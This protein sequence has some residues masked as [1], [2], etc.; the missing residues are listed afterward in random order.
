MK[1][2]P[3]QVIKTYSISLSEKEIKEIFQCLNYCSHRL[4]EHN[5]PSILSLGRIDNMRKAIG[6][7]IGLDII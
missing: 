2:E 3:K 1:I 5:P 4:R 6:D 7:T